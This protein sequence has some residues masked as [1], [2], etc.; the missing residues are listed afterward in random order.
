VTQPTGTN[1]NIQIKQGDTNCNTGMSLSR[2]RGN[3]DSAVGLPPNDETGEYGDRIHQTKP[4]NTEPQPREPNTGKVQHSTLTQCQPLVS[5][6]KS[7]HPSTHTQ[8]EDQTPKTTPLRR[9]PPPQE[10]YSRTN[11]PEKEPPKQMPSKKKINKNTRASLK[12]ASLNMRG[13]G[14]DKW[15]HINQIMRDH[16][17][18][19]LALQET[20][21]ENKHVD[22]LHTLFS[23]RLKIFHTINP[24]EP[25]SK[26]VAIVLNKEITNI[27]NVKTRVLIHGRALLMTLPWHLDLEIKIL[28]TYA[29]NAPS[30]NETFWTTLKEIWQTENLPKPDI[31]LGDHNIVEDPIDRMPSHSD[32]SNAV[33]ALCNLRY[34]FQVHD[35][36]RYTNPT[37]KEYTFLQQTTGSHSRIDRIY[38]SDKLLK[39]SFDWNIW[40]PGIPT[41][42]KI[43]SVRITNPKSPF[44]GKG[45]WTI[46]LH[47]LKNKTL[48]DEIQSLART[49]E[50]NLNREKTQRT[51]RMNPQT[52]FK[53]F[54]DNIILKAR[55]LAKVAIPKINI[56][57]KKLESELKSVLNA[58]NTDEQD[59]I[60]SGISLQEQIENLEKIKHHNTRSQMD[61]RNKLEGET[62][63]KY[64]TQLNKAKTPRDTIYALKHP[65]KSPPTYETKSSNMAE[66]AK[67]YHNDLQ[68]KD[69]PT[70]GAG[71]KNKLQSILDLIDQT[72]EPA[73]QEK[74]EQYL[75]QEEIIQ[76]LKTSP[77]GK[78]AGPDGIPSELWKTMHEQY[79]NNKYS[80]TKAVDITKILQTIYNDIEQY[81][82]NALTDFASGWICPIYKKGDIKDIANYRPITILNADYKMF[83]K[84]LTNKLTI[85]TNKLIHEDQ[86]AF[87]PGRSISDQIKLTKLLID[88]A[89]TEEL[90]GIIVALDQEKAY[91]KI[92]H[93]YMWTTLKKFGI[94]TKFT[95]ILQSIYK[96]A[97]STVTINGVISEPFQII[98]G[99]RQGDPLSCLLFNLSIEPLAIMIRKSTIKG[100]TIP[101]MPK[102]IKTTLFAD[103]TTIYMSN[104]D[105]FTNMQKVLDTWCSVSGAKFNLSKT[106]IIPIGTKDYR[107]TVL[108]TRR[109]NPGQE[110]I[111]NNIHLAKD[112]EPV[113]ILGAWIGNNVDQCGIWSKT[114]DKIEKSLEQWT[115]SHPTMEG[116]KLI[117]QMVIAGMTQY[118]TK[119]QGMPQDIERRLIKRIRTFIWNKESTPPIATNILTLPI[120]K[121][122]KKLLDLQARNKAIQLT[123]L[124][125][126][127]QM[128]IYRPK[129]AFIAD[130]LIKK[131]RLTT[132]KNSD[133]TSLENIFTQSWKTNIHKLPTDIKEMLK[134]AKEF[135]VNLDTLQP[136]QDLKGKLPIWMHIG[137]NELLRI[138]SS[139]KEAK[140]LKSK[141]RINKVEQLRILATR[142]DENHKPRGNCPCLRCR[143][144]RQENGCKNPHK[145]HIMAK[146]ILNT[147]N[148]KWNPLHPPPKD[149]LD[150]TPRRKRKNTQAE[151]NN[152][153]IIFDPKISSNN[154]NETIRVFTDPDEV[155][156][157]PAIRYNS[158]DE[159]RQEKKTTIYTD[160]SCIN[161]G[162]EN[163]QAGSGIWYGPNDPRNIALRVPGP[164]QTNQ[165][166]ELYAILQGVKNTAKQDPLEIISDSKYCIDGLTKHTQKWEDRGWIEISNKELFKTTV[167]WLRQR[168]SETT[169]RWVKGHNNEDGNEEADKLAALGA[170]LPTAEVMDLSLPENFNL[171]GAK[172]STMTQATLYKGICNTKTTKYRTKTI[173]QLDITR[174]AIEQINGSL[175]SDETIWKSIRKKN[176][177]RP[178]RE[179][180]WKNLH[181][182]QRCGPFWTN[183]PNQEHKGVCP[184]CQI[185]ESMEHILT[186]CD[187]PGQKI[188]WNLTSELWQLKYEPLPRISYGT[189]MGCGLSP[190]KD[191]NKHPDTGKNRLFQI[192]ISES[193]YLIWKIRC[194]RRIE[195][196]DNPDKYHSYQEIHN[197]WVATINKRLLQ[198]CLSTDRRRYGR[199]ATD[200][201]LVHQTWKSIL[202][203]EENLPERWFRQ[204]G[205]LVGIRPLR[206]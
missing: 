79:K 202:W 123:W 73:D 195:R 6:P 167:A 63:S 81:G 64:W 67:K 171:T 128:D 206:S 162:E 121:G 143:E 36:W 119:V 93:E 105:N 115:K 19:V 99:V 146:K 8:P 141:H 40:T 66:L 83:T 155:R 22:Q 104:S 92:A 15:N 191:T 199:K 190:Y 169:L 65:D 77:N 61:I 74:L 100:Y 113:R 151:E 95:K 16:K 188:I 114:L 136:S 42:H 70:T 161:N 57:I 142:Q 94:P 145:C 186:D 125:T 51:E 50:Q 165:T 126:Y 96:Q 150:L 174:W 130:Q 154:I 13:R 29:P 21:L 147:L 127:M 78:A 160:G 175:P 102:T 197:R 68:K 55:K 116:R 1:Q 117:V 91:D 41:D 189:V 5:N 30:E 181:Q 89:E 45:R 80:N 200:Q 28:A 134:M 101:G 159:M 26:G 112:G 82:V 156:P 108:T 107:N 88:Y 106:E 4:P 35:G 39:H 180:L 137:A 54:K 69:K 12:I 196:E 44:I 3:Q 34:I 14:T 103:D 76:A 122:G 182:A 110:P 90:N 7:V 144:Q 163:A 173:A 157:D 187:A 49:L 194:E 148:P 11:T 124:K 176:L 86:A 47:L 27:Q 60:L 184:T 111:P 85:I 168:T 177:S 33:E 58:Q 204:S 153:P 170:L 17:I 178:I 20:H 31:F 84:A 132:Y 53:N 23:K 193:A 203:D 138:L 43:T 185:E 56:E 164:T 72:V 152:N 179:F 149:N 48:L 118:L 52:L 10:P 38:I 75:E 97:K 9:D 25:N 62:I 183:I 71:Y 172:L 46:P 198:D 133:Q 18:G 2:N 109:I 32:N 59:K 98:R 158:P 192:L 135:N 120:A 201:N 87:L 140:C 129:W 139:Y 205:V 166:A 37:T 131:N 24:E